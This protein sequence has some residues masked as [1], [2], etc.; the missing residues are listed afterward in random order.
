MARYVALLRGI[1]VGGKNIIPMADLR[2]SFEKMGFEDVSTYIQS[3]N[4]FFEGGPD[5]QATALT[6][7]I[8]AGLKA[9]FG[10]DASLVLRTVRQLRSIVEGAPPGFGSDPDYRV[11]VAFLKAPLTA[12]AAL[13]DVP[14]NPEVDRVI[15]GPGVLYLSRVAAQASKSR[16]SRL[17]SRAIYRQMTIRNWPTTTTLLERLRS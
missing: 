13:R 9:S 14:T 5:M 3:G 16:L 4:V 17:S 1:N 6:S 2:C 12:K 10:Y 8:E 11:D 15:P 7:R